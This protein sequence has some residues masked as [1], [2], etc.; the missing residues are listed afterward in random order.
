MEQRVKKYPKVSW[1]S[2]PICVGVQKSDGYYSHGGE[3]RLRD[4][5]ARLRAGMVETAA[6]GSSVTWIVEPDWR[7][8][9]SAMT[10]KLLDSRPSSYLPGGGH[11]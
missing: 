6:I 10:Q 7:R 9:N 3:Q 4:G 11:A 5:H 8:T 1:I 2:A